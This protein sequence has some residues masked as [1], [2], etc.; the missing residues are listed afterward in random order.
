MHV[1]SRPVSIP[2]ETSSLL[3]RQSVATETES[4]LGNETADE[5]SGLLQDG[6]QLTTSRYEEAKAI[7]MWSGPLIVTYLIQRSVNVMGVIAVGR[8]GPQELGAV[9]CELST[10]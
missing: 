8:I 7:T 10:V 2:T 3:R 4:T 6:G 9:S 1:P 5:Q